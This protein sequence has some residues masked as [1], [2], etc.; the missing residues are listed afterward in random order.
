MQL[1]IKACEDRLQRLR[2]P[3]TTKR[4][5]HIYLQ[6]ISSRLSALVRAAIDGVYVDHFFESFTDQ[7]DRLERWLR[8]NVQMI[9]SKYAEGMRING[10]A[11]EVVEDDMER[12]SPS[13]YVIRDTYLVEV[14]DRMVECRGRELPGTFNPLVVGD[15]FS[16]QCKPWEAITQ[17]LVEEIHEAAATT[18]NKMASEICDQ[19]TKSRLIKGHIQPSLHRLR[20]DLKA[21]VNEFLEPHLSIHPITYDDYLTKNVQAIQLTRHCRILDHLSMA[22]CWVTS[23]ATATSKLDRNE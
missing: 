18:F 7:G 19:N 3:R 23:E 13:K 2:A 9:L 15:L 1:G 5:R 6:R 4:E 12:Q 20:K 11:F 8:A 16:R 22:A 14:E 21:K 17:D 10:H